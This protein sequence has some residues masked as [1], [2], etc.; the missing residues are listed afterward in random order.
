MFP[1]F[2]LLIASVSADW[3]LRIETEPTSESV[4]A[5]SSDHV[6]ITTSSGESAT[7]TLGASDED[8]R[9][10]TKYATWVRIA[11]SG[12]DG[13]AVKKVLVNGVKIGGS[14]WLDLPCQ[15]SYST[16]YNTC[17]E[18]IE[19]LVDLG[20]PPSTSPTTSEPSFEPTSS[21]PSFQPTTSAPTTAEPSFSPTVGTTCELTADMNSNYTAIFE[22]VICL[23]EEYHSVG[24][25]VGKGW[26][27]PF[28]RRYVTTLASHV[29]ILASAQSSENFMKKWKKRFEYAESLSEDDDDEYHI[30][31]V[32]RKTCRA[33]MVLDM[34][35]D[36]KRFAQRLD[37]NDEN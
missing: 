12:Q 25:H 37:A 6:V 1:I 23:C 7:M 36:M 35:D 22:E 2:S 11:S 20:L 19:Y 3:T 21:E 27:R 26:L 28:H 5:G 34:E 32:W 8:E 10:F 9:T 14:F 30:K 16:D 17:H 4:N 15:S 29:N 13:L 18:S 33:L 24:T 31:R